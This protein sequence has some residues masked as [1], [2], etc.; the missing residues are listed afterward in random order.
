MT[1][2]EKYNGDTLMTLP[3]VVDAIYY[4]DHTV[5]D[6]IQHKD[7]LFRKDETIVYQTVTLEIRQILSNKKVKTESLVF[8]YPSDYRRVRYYCKN[9]T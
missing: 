6:I 4:K 3:C 5:L 1:I 2:V 9:L 7:Q 8:L